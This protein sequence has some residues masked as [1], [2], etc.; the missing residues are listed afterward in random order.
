M[1]TTALLL[2]SCNS[3]DTTSS[4]STLSK[5]SK[6]SRSNSVKIAIIGDQ[7]IGE[8]SQK[9]LRLIKQ[10]KAELLLING[11]FDYEN[12]PVA[13][14][15][16]NEEIL[17]ED[18]PIIAVTGNHDVPRWD[19]YQQIIQEWEQ[20]P[21]LDCNGEAGVRT[22]CTYKGIQ[23][24]SASPGIFAN[25]SPSVDEKFIKDSFKDSD[26]IWRICQWHKNMH[27]MQTGSKGDETGWGVYEECRNQGAMITTGHEHAYARSYLFSNIEEKEIVS[28]SNEM[29]IE[30]GKTIVAL[31]GLG[32]ISSRPLVHDGYW[33]ASKE[34][35]DT[36][37]DAGVLFCSYDLTSSLATCY[38]MDENSNTKDVFYLRNN[39]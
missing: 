27:D 1:L 37:V 30:K 25:Q 8:R 34:N 26:S 5:E 19:E 32:G 9:I 7:G 10:Q 17:G 20:N 4:L 6:D 38:F 14:K 21:K 3:S 23:I 29:S 35:L 13:W 15:R 31:S 11:D 18:F 2:S 12:D 16:I 33:W 22:T 39:L 28:T 36:G 24:V